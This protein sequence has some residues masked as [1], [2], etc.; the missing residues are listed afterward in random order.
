[1]RCTACD[2]ETE[3]APCSSCGQEPR[4]DGRYTLVRVI[5]RGAHGTTW[6]A[7]APD[8]DRVALK[9][10]VLG[11]NVAHKTTEL[12]EREAAVL[13]QLEHPSIPTFVEAFTTGTGRMRCF[14][15]V[16]E[17][18]EGHTLAAELERHRYTEDEVLAIGEEIQAILGYLHGLSP[19]VVHRDLKPANTS[20]RRCSSP[21][22]PR[23]RCGTNTGRLCFRGGTTGR[24]CTCSAWSAGWSPWCVRRCWSR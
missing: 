3:Q 24:R 22:T 4:L 20:W 1:M 12:W 11:R 21:R 13:R 2:E 16:Q 7:L 9:E 19:P 17:F 8:G 18:V 15:V 6:E 5:G 14:C 23:C 10:M